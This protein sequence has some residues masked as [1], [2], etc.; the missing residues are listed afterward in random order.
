MGLCRMVQVALTEVISSESCNI[1]A[2]SDD[3]GDV[4]LP[5]L[6]KEIEQKLD[7][8]SGSTRTQIDFIPNSTRV[9]TLLA[10]PIF[11]LCN[12]SSTLMSP[13]QLGLDEQPDTP[14]RILR[15]PQS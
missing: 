4:L 13:A 6:A 9:E 7:D 1:I 14:I 8:K 10:R 12:A 5:D 3:H 11:G 15:I 2:A